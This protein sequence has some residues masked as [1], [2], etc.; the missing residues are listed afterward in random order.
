MLYTEPHL[1]EGLG[2]SVNDSDILTKKATM[3]K[4]IKG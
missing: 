4:R 3:S 2:L 1:V